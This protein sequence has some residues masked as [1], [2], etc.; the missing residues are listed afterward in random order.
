MTNPPLPKTFAAAFEDWCKECDCKP[1][2]EGFQLSLAVS[3]EN[4]LRLHLE[5]AAKAQSQLA[6]AFLGLSLTDKPVAPRL[7]LSG[8][9]AK[10]GKERLEC[11]G[12]NFAETI[13]RNAGTC[14]FNPSSKT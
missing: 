14:T 1:G 13:L 2:D 3:F 10:S 6:D 11:S 9:G 7:I 4:F 5:A 8:S 12:G